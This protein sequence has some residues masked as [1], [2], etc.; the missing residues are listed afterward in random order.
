MHLRDFIW[1]L[2]IL[3]MQNPRKVKQVA[4][5]EIPARRR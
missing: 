4:G 2:T 5:S 1:R 3:V